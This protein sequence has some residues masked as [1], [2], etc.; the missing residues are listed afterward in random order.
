MKGMSN[1]TKVPGLIKIDMDYQ[2]LVLDIDGTLINSKKEISP[3]TKEALINI[4]EQGLIIVLA[5]GRP[6]QGIRLI[7]E[8][9]QLGRFGNYILSYNGAK[10]INCGTGEVI[11]RKILPNEVIPQLYDEAIRHNVG[12]LTY[13]NDCIIAGTKPDGYMIIESNINGI[14]II[15]VDDF[16]TYVTFDIPKCL[17]TGLPTHLEKVEK[18]LKS[19]Y[20]NYLNI[21]RSEPFFL[22]VM[23]QNIDKAN[24]LSK[25]LGSLSL[26]ADQMICCGDGFNDISMIEYAGLGIAM[27]NAQELVKDVSDYVTNSNDEDGILHVI[28][29]FIRKY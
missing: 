25:L 11:F 9:I 14:P 12:I 19:K 24:S 22:E 6:T 13:N 20:N 15:E 8:Q 2:M 17:M 5:S 4:Q 29:R 21:Y 18:I 10:I 28:N 1:D 3:A 27:Q 23:P 16:K 26:T 7:A